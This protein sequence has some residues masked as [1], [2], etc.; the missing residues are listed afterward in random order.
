MDQETFMND[1]GIMEEG[2]IVEMEDLEEKEE[3]QCQV[4]LML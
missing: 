3:E 4:P 2:N 1:W